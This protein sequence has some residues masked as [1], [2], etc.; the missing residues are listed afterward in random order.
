MLLSHAPCHNTTRHDTTTQATADGVITLYFEG[1]EFASYSSRQESLAVHLGTTFLGQPMGDD[2]GA[3]I[4][5]TASAA[6]STSVMQCGCGVCRSRLSLAPENPNFRGTSGQQAQAETMETTMVT[7]SAVGMLV[8]LGIRPN[9]AGAMARLSIISRIC[10]ETGSIVLGRTINPTGLRLGDHEDM[11]EVNGALVGSVMIQTTLLLVSLAIAS[12]MYRVINKKRMQHR[13]FT[14]VLPDEFEDRKSKDFLL[15]SKAARQEDREDM[16]GDGKEV[17]VVHQGLKRK[18]VNYIMARGRFGWILI[19]ATFLF[20]GTAMCAV[21]ALIYSTPFFKFVAVCDILIF[22]LGIVAYATHIAYTTKKYAEVE[23][24][25]V[26]NRNIVFKVLWGTSEW[27]T[28]PGHGKG[29]WVELNHLLYDGYRHYARFFLTY[30]LIVSFALGAIGA[31]RP[32]S[33]EQCW[34]KSALTLGVLGVFLLT[35][36]CLR[37]YLAPYENVMEPSIAAVEMVLVALLM[38]AMREDQPA[39]S[40]YAKMATKLGLVAMYMIVLKASLDMIIFTVDEYGI[41]KELNA[42]SKKKTSFLRHFLFCGNNIADDRLEDYVVDYEV[43]DVA[44]KDDRLSGFDEC[45][46]DDYPS[47]GDEYTNIANYNLST[48]SM[49]H[50]QGKKRTRAFSTTVGEELVQTPLCDTQRNSVRLANTCKYI[51]SP[52]EPPS[53]GTAPLQLGET[54][55]RTHRRGA[56][57]PRL[58]KN[59]LSRHTGSLLGR[60]RAPMF[61]DAETC[62]GRDSVSVLGDSTSSVSKSASPLSPLGADT[63]YTPRRMRR[64]SVSS[65]SSRSNSGSVLLPPV[66]TKAQEG[67]PRPPSRGGPGRGV[68]LVEV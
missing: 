58:E 22:I 30:E 2:C 8:G 1:A 55:P 46:T 28:L 27:V 42:R 41:W 59:N 68:H 6:L 16:L 35:L 49:V 36:L 45:I 48:S 61:L 5:T 67:A 63:G 40:W 25:D 3:D 57:S 31:W 15:K 39:K 26:P 62:D 23:P 54:S 10:P 56:S 9:T 20:G 44:S 32:S 50:T 60:G 4:P 17:R 64:A 34:T 19:P 29:A 43:E 33:M 37:P 13:A 53:Q 12:V 51:V 21:S 11:E 14:T 38:L 47:S 65:F 52:P 66:R 24:I 7:T 18:E